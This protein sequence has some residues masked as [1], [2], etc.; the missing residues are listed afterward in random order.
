[1]SKMAKQK[2]HVH[3]PE[4]YHEHNAEPKVDMQV[5]M[6][7]QVLNQQL[8]EVQQ[9][10][11]TAGQQMSEILVIIEAVSDLGKAQVGSEMLAP[12]APGIF[13]RSKLTDNK[14]VLINV[15]NNVVVGKS[16]EETK[17]LLNSQLAE[18]RNFEQ[19]LAMHW[20][21]TVIRLQEIQ[22]QLK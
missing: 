13:V 9:K 11:T 8:K 17:S 7:F 19:N 2:E 16:L 5:Y 1:M 20:Q 18:L 10:L 4:C 3:G 12:M 15:G 21:Q 22:E 14:E 6:E